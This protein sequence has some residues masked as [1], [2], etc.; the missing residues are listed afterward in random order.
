MKRV[1][2]FLF[3]L[4]L[5]GQAATAQDTRSTATRIADA[6]ALL[7]AKDAA[8]AGVAY[9]ELISLDD[10]ALEK[11]IEGI[12]PSGVQAG[13]A[14]RYAV[15]LLAQQAARPDEVSRIE[16]ALLAALSKSSD[17]EVSQY[18]IYYIAR[19]GT[20]RSVPALAGLLANE[21]LTEPSIEAL[22]A[23][24][25]QEAM[26]ALRNGISNK[27][28]SVQIRIIQA[29]GIRRD[30]SAIALLTPLT[31]STEPLVRREALWSLALIG[32]ASSESLL[33]EQSAAAGYKES[34]T[35][36]ME[37]L[38]QYMT[39]RG[40][41][42]AN[43]SMIRSRL[44]ENTM[45]AEQ[46]HFRLA[47][48]KDLVR[49]VPSTS[50]PQLAAEL[51]RFDASY[52]RDVLAAAV[53][54]AGDP[55]V[56]DA[57]I[58]VYK[59]STGDKQAEILTMLSKANTDEG[60]MNQ[61]IVPALESKN[62]AVRVAALQAMGATHVSR[63]ADQAGTFMLRTDITD[64]E[65]EE[66]VKC[67]L[68]LA[69]LSQV[70]SLVKQVRPG[71]TNGAV[72]VIGVVAARRDTDD[73]S[74]V[75]ANTYAPNPA[76]R[77]A[78]FSALPNVSSP[79]VIQR[80]LAM[81]KTAN[82]TQEIAP[83]Q[84]ALI[85]IAGPDT[86]P[87]ILQ[88]ASDQKARL[89]PVLPYIKDKQ[90][91]QMVRTSFEQG[92]A[93]E[94]ELAFA[95]LINWQNG[96]AVPLLLS[97]LR[98]GSKLYHGRAF[99]AY[100]RQTMATDWPA[101]Q[102]LLKLREVFPL[103]ATVDEKK[104]ILREAG[105]IRTFLSF[106]FVSSWLDDV[107]LGPT[108]SRSTMRLAL[109]TADA[110]PGLT[111]KEV[112]KA[113]EKVMEKLTGPDS[114]YDRIDVKSYLDQL[115]YVQG[116]ESIFNGT[117]LDGW[118]GLVE[119][120]IARAK[121]T[122]EELAKKQAVADAKITDNWSVK[123]GMICFTGTGENLCTKRTFGDFEMLVDW[124]ISKN[125]DSGIYLRGSPQVQIWDTARVDVGAQVGSGGL[126]NNTVNRNPLVVADNPIGE[127]NTLYIKMIGERVTVYLNGT[128]VVDNIVMENYW[129]RKIPIF[130]NGP[131]ELQ[132]HGTELAFRNVYVRELNKPY[133]LTA[134]EKLQGFENL[135]NGNDLSGWVGNK[136]DYVV[137]DH[138][139]SIY[140]TGR[141]KGNLYTER[142]FSNFIFRFEFMLTPAGNNG[143]GIHAPL[144][145]DAAYVGKEIQILDNEH[146]TYANLQP[147]QYHGSVYGVIPAKRGFLRPTGDW[148][149][150][151]VEVRGDKIKVT[152]NGTIILDGDWKKA[153]EKGTM[154]KQDHPG[155]QRHTGHIG[156]LGHGSVV[157]FR[158]IRIKT[159]P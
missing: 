94:K 66:A 151:E 45:N 5:V 37:A 133:E 47:A 74:F 102:K 57:W 142:E 65:R 27:P 138:V 82:S 115:P 100:V 64:Q 121:M 110:Q 84:Q 141:G 79:S 131:I 18:Y 145:G 54:A 77:A 17:R 68:Q 69:E 20:S 72:A 23:I 28:S 152:L 58:K 29:L 4:L 24:G 6:L 144:E 130:P 127:W 85:A 55:K 51:D 126:Y 106:V 44:L 53:T 158:N 122:K 111:G 124:K 139:I 59:K 101:E 34:P 71:N 117:N 93:E 56:R 21:S 81:L 60:F 112:R 156:F 40:A 136:T 7:P 109:P 31:K 80:L 26:A 91:L 89:L 52:R 155:L 147:Y 38:I 159:L 50:Q 105:G 103:A 132:A 118:Q 15:A 97:V 32:D 3:V 8:T 2:Y 67:F 92:Q 99:S 88:A 46:Q 137:D 98:Q 63:Y 70:R 123:D 148:N 49:S 108:A 39:V 154:D 146:P 62:Q 96:D 10:A 1:L 104:L 135:F 13:V 149:V 12:R 11:V 129:D 86:A 78:A 25:T 90:S 143:L 116:Y 113:L 114:Q 153:S 75:I 83:V 128:L 87:T 36:E 14:Y 9:A 120:P 33:L 76:I 30:K 125:G 22:Q 73:A 150:E 19:L 157:K 43:T 35:Q 119:N 134:E 95:A 48:L 42:G 107:E 16:S 41:E 140:P 61:H